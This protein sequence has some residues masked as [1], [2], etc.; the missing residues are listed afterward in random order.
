M[1][2]APLLDPPEPDDDEIELADFERPFTLNLDALIAG[3]EAERAEK[4]AKMQEY[5]R[6]LRLNPLWAQMPHQGEYGYKVKHGI[7]LNGTESRGQVEFLELTKLQVYLAAVVASNRWGK[8]HS[9]VLDAAIQTLPWEFIPPWLRPYKKLDPA[10]RD[11]RM[12]FIGPDKDHWRDRTIVPKMRA[13]LPP[14]ALLGGSFDKA[15]RS[16]EGVLTFADGSWWDFLTHDMETDAFA[17][18]D[19]DSARIDEELTGEAGRDK[20]DETVRGLID[21]NG[22]IRITMT[23]VEGIGWIRD[24]LVDEYGEPRR[25][26]DAWV[27]T[28]RIEHNPHIGRRG[29]EQAK[30][31]WRKRD[32][33]TFA[34]RA[35][36]KWVHREGLIFPE[37]VRSIEVA[38]GEPGGGHL[39]I[40]RELRA[41]GGPRD[42]ET[43]HWLVPVFESID[44]GINVNHPFAF[45]VGFLNSASTDV[46]GM[47]D[48]LELFFSIK[49][50]DL[51]VNQQAQLVFEA[52]H[53]FG[54][55]PTFTVMDPASA[56]QRN[57]QSGKQLI[58]LWREEGI[59][60]V[61]GQNS[62]PLTYEAVHMRLNG[63][64]PAGA[65]PQPSTA[66][67]RVWESLD[68]II[69]D[70]FANYRWHKPIRQ[71]DNVPSPQPVKR[72]D[73]CIDTIRYM[74]TRIPVWRGGGLP[75]EDELPEVMRHP[76][77]EL[78]RRHLRDLRRRR[79]RGRGKTGNVWGR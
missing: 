30:A 17:S 75:I 55:R 45:T 58:A 44:P 41:P 12:R 38:P 29:R 49:L 16:R 77:R 34:A 27:V 65:P 32:P 70:E 67:L 4:M 20:W 61:T 21:R 62:R 69:G 42:V 11:I 72:N 40:D 5:R 68:A 50:P 31:R 76:Q 2:A 43:G 1:T 14:G 33:Q 8:T 46:Y 25:D 47:D 66:R 56:V 63:Q 35:E 24:E 74:V 54:Y 23:P 18:V 3:D 78:L 28:G 59:Y 13:L 64:V 9:N 36:G 51:T 60:P 39:R 7:P 79:G 71:T 37:F 22:C 52:R 73:D 26:R 53:E 10:V 6:L 48:V 19:I 15:W 57:Q